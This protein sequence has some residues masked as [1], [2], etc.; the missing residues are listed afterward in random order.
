MDSY[1]HFIFLQI[2]LKQRIETIKYFRYNNQEMNI[3]YSFV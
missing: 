1:E 3:D 2:V